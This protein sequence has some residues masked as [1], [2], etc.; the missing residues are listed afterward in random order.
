MFNNKLQ[1]KWFLHWINIKQ[2]SKWQHFESIC[3][4]W[5]LNIYILYNIFW[6]CSNGEKM[7]FEAGVFWS[8][9]I[10]KKS[11]YFRNLRKMKNLPFIIILT[12]SILN[13][14]IYYAYILITYSS[15]FELMDKVCH[16]FYGWF[17]E[18]RQLI[19]NINYYMY[20]CNQSQDPDSPWPN[21]KW[22]LIISEG[23]YFTPTV[24]K[25]PGPWLS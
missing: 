22:A 12:V 18:V 15:D 13:A 6:F 14:I 20:Q 23:N 25:F 10:I 2:I 16:Y 17:I 7:W 21:I 19:Q 9:D 5:L 24:F 4:A 1:H 11:F 8:I 3:T